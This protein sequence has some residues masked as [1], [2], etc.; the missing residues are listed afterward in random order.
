[1]KMPAPMITPIPKTTRST[2]VS[3]FLSWYSGS[4]ASWRDCWMLLV[5][6]TFI[7]PP[8]VAS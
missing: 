2:A 5:R 6:R 8:V 7:G 1:V 4:S 3:R